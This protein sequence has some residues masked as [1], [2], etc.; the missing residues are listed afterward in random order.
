VS[1]AVDQISFAKPDVQLCPFGAY[2]ELFGA[3]KRVHRDPLTTFWEVLG[4][5]ELMKIVQNPAL[6]SSEHMLYGEKTHTP[7]YAEAKRMY[8]EQSFPFVP[9]LINADEP[10][11]KRNRA[12]VDVS[13]R[14]ARVKAA[15]PYIR[16]LVNLLIDR[17]GDVDQVEFMTS[18]A[19]LLPLYVIADTI[20]VPR[21]RALDFKRWSDA[22]I[23]VHDPAITADDQIRLTRV[24]IEMQLFF[25]EEYARAKEASG[26]NILGDVARARI[27]GEEVSAQLAISIIS[28]LLVAGNETTTSVL[29]SAMKRLIETPGLDDLLRANP[30]RIP[31]FIE[32]VLRLESPLPCQFRRN[33]EEVEIAGTIIPKDSLIVLRFG[34]ANRDG[35]RWENPD[36]FDI[37]RP[38][39]RYH[40]AFGGGI[41]MCIGHLLARAELRIAYEELLKRF[42]NFRMNGEATAIPSYITYGPRRL[43]IA[44]DRVR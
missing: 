7:A 17:W 43:P 23:E 34:G 2:R 24:V 3:G 35:E 25:A 38:K 8:E 10:I 37:D 1:D 31:N 6:F 41:H 16:E 21:E 33:T 5:D 28:G 32:E 40:L 18:F 29:G 30:A 19:E 44:F 39:S 9:S 15:E 42:G 14:P 26:E 13:F 4:H 22:L 11:H 36:N 27:D 12:L 20:G